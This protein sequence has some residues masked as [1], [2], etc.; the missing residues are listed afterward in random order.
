MMCCVLFD[1][2][3]EIPKGWPK[4]EPVVQALL[5]HVK[6]SLTGRCDR[7]E[8]VLRNCKVEEGATMILC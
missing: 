3:M 7:G 5:S 2:E 6:R 4:D 8:Q 1:G